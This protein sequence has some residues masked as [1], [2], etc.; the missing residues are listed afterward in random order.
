MAKAS[1]LYGQ[2][3]SEIAEYHN[4]VVDSLKLFFSTL[5][6]RTDLRYVGSS[7]AEID[8]ILSKRLEETELRSAL[9]VLSSVEAAL[10]IDYL[11]RSTRRK[12]D[13][14]SRDFRSLYKIN[15]ERVA[16]SEDILGLWIKHHPELRSLIGQL[17]SALHFR[18]W[19]GPWAILGL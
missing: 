10:R 5:T 3:L 9:A 2:S 15:K 7:S 16:L 19:L 12:K 17:R 6:A 11:L 4:N 18:H 8:V 13:P 1:D 14:L